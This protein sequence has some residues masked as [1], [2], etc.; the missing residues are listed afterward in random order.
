M[1]NTGCLGGVVG[2]SYTHGFEVGL[3]VLGLEA[4]DFGGGGEADGFGDVGKLC[5]FGVVG[6]A[7]SDAGRLFLGEFVDVFCKC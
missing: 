4:R 5:D 2:C 1:I 3:K 7:L 6:T